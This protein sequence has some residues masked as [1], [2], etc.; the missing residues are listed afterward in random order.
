MLNL[1]RLQ[2]IRQKDPHLG[3]TID[4]L[5]RAVNRVASQL[6]VE[7]NGVVSKPDKPVKLEV[8]AADGFYDVKI[9]DPSPKTARPLFYFLEY[10]TDAK[11]TNPM[12][13]F[14]GTSR[15]MRLALGNQQLFFRA[16]SQHFGSSPSDMVYA[17]GGCKIAGGGTASGPE[18]P[19]ES[20]DPDA[21]PGTGGFGDGHGLNLP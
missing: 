14:M 6:G 16:F 20:A 13:V 5:Q 9:V 18:I 8:V 2:E 12:S 7:P 17:G 19:G 1:R 21:P 15:S 10:A 3:E 11:F 4:D